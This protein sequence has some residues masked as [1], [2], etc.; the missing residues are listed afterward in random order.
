MQISL[1]VEA[2]ARTMRIT[3]GMAC[4]LKLRTPQGRGARP[5]LDRV[6]E[7]IFNMLGDLRGSRVADL[8]AGAG[9]LGLEALSRGAAFALFVENNRAHV[10]VLKSNIDLVCD[11]LQRGHDVHP[12][13]QV[14]PCAVHLLPAR[15]RPL[16]GTFDVV[17]ADPPYRTPS[18]KPGAAE[19]LEAPDLVDWIGDAL[20][21]IEHNSSDHLQPF[22]PS[23]LRVLRSRKYGGTAVTVLAR[24]SK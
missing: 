23:T 17:L 14:I 19:I 3:G 6:R 22:I 9:T 18:G 13:T 15:A 5:T 8:Y 11:T 2:N 21:V 12:R 24:A 10:Q 1:F 4:G 7:A 20:L 16:A